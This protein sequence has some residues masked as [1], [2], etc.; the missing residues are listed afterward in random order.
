VNED[1]TLSHCLAGSL[2]LSS[3][4]A[5]RLIS[6]GA[7]Y[8][9]RRRTTSDCAVFPGQYIRVHLKPRRYSVD[10]IDWRKRIVYE[11]TELVVV[12]KPAGIP[13]HATLDNGIE[14]VINQLGAVLAESLFVTQRLDT[15]VGGL[16][17][18]GKTPEFQSQFNRLLAE[19][20]V[21]KQYR[22]LVTTLPETGR[23]VHYMAP[24]KR[25]PKTLSTQA[26]PT[27]LHCALSVLKAERSTHSLPASCAYDVEIDLETGRTH[28][29]RAQLSAMGS[30][31][32]G[33]TLYGSQTAF[34]LNGTT[35]PGIALFST[36]SSWINADGREYSFQQ[37][38]TW[39][40]VGDGL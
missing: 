10:G 38:P 8:V 14:N 31:I 5:G 21:R 12:N 1:A 33:D 35:Y 36:L 30:S 18:L 37:S 27:W 32:V 6:F 15:E 9:E 28:Q 16:L 11:D 24:T 22:A 23:H 26:Q 39:T 29:I 25:G 4:E 3:D 13:V 34:C 20:K 17:V 2:E 7:V 19:R 40:N